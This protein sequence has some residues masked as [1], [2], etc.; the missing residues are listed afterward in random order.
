MMHVIWLYHLF[1]AEVIEKL[2]SETESLLDYLS[3]ILS[4]LVETLPK[5]NFI[6]DLR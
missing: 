1:S 4:T 2:S 3:I 5:D 6:E